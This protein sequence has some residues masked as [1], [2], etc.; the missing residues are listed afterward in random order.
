MAYH[1]EFTDRAKKDI[2]AHKKSGDKTVL[3]N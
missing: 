2:E 1:L 3:K